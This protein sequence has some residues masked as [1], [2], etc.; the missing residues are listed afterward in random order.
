MR[1]ISGKA[2]FEHCSSFGYLLFVHLLSR[3]TA[4]CL[5]CS[6]TSQSNQFAVVY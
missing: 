6:H 4:K 3:E 5:L 2:I 1:A